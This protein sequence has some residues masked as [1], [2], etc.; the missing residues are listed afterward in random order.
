MSRPAARP[1]YSIDSFASARRPSNARASPRLL[2][3]LTPTPL[4]QRAHVPHRR[5]SQSVTMGRTLGAASRPRAN[6]GEGWRASRGV[7][8]VAWRGTRAWRQR[9]VQPRTRTLD[10]LGTGAYVLRSI[11]G[12]PVGAPLAGTRSS[13]CDA[14]QD[15][16]AAGKRPERQAVGEA[17]GGR[18]EARRV[19]LAMRKEHH[20]LGHGASAWRCARN[21]TRWGTGRARRARRA[22]RACPGLKISW[23]GSR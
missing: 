11:P 10:A 6:T 4:Q 23:C 7:S 18:G 15:L 20:T 3:S 5:P 14:G 21:I 17:G 13:T 8:R 9:C 22:R 16:V 19:G 2:L 1:R 12:A